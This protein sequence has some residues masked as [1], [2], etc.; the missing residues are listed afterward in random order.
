MTLPHLGSFN[1]PLRY[2]NTALG[3]IRSQPKK[4]FLP[5]PQC[6][7]RG[8]VL[9]DHHHSRHPNTKHPARDRIKLIY[10]LPPG[11]A[12]KNINWYVYWGN[13]D[14]LSPFLFFS[15]IALSKPHRNQGKLVRI[16]PNHISVAEP[17]ALQIVYAVC[18]SVHNN[19]SNNSHLINLHSCLGCLSMVM[20][21]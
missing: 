14:D 6:A 2:A 7:H 18:S 17:E 15:L 12:G 21:G 16:A 4:T 20:A 9:P 19:N 5:P 11:F 1:S 13:D 8:F 3:P 10:F